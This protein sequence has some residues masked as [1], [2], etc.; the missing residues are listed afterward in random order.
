MTIDL[1]ADR[2]ISFEDAI[3]L[4]EKLLEQIANLSEA[5]KTAIIS[6]LVATE[7]GARGLFVTYLTS[8]NAMVDHPSEGII[9]GLKTSPEI[10]SELLVKNVAMSTAMR[11]THTRNH[12]PELADSSLKVTQRS[13]N[14]INQL[15]LPEIK[16]KIDLLA[17]TIQEEKGIY[18]EF[19]TRWGYD[20]QQKEMIL[21]TLFNL[22]PAT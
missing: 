13:L 11:I 4:T 20:Q 16:E 3:A 22:T 5:E 14:L 18:Q 2:N 21:N 9:N 15:S 17:K 1:I 8:D 19:L 7:N 6:S 12:N 10:V